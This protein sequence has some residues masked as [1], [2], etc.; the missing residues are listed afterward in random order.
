[1]TRAA[2]LLLIA[3]ARASFTRVKF[4]VITTAGA[5][6][7]VVR[8]HETWA[9]RGAQH[10]LELVAAEYFDDSRFFRYVEGFVVQFGLAG[11]PALTS[12]W[13]DAIKDDPV[14]TSNR[15]GTLAFATAGRDTRTT[16]L[17]VNLA[18][19]A[20]LDAQGF[21]PFG[22]LEA[23]GLAVARAVYDCGDD[24]EQHLIEL[25]G[26]TY[27]DSR[28]PQ[29]SRVVRARVVS[30]LSGVYADPNHPGC[31]RT[32][33]QRSES[34]A[35]VSGEDAAGAGSGAC[36]EGGARV[37]WGPLPAVLGEDAATGR[38]SLAVDFSSKGGPANLTGVWD[39]A[40]QHIVWAD[41]NVWTLIGPA[42]DDDGG[43]SPARSVLWGGGLPSAG[44]LISLT[45]VA[46]TIAFA[47][48][49]A[50]L[51]VTKCRASGK[52]AAALPQ[53][54]VEPLR[55][56][57]DAL[58]DDDLSDVAPYRDDS[59]VRATLPDGR[60]IELERVHAVQAH[61]EMPTRKKEAQD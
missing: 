26:N 24:P 1:M 28:F 52:P 6:S 56:G 34:A 48:N 57:D 54:D 35:E 30:S 50:Y 2:L 36:G 3:V 22:V 17:F 55:S 10:F 4:D 11:S 23:G 9:P 8:V 47:C 16:Q 39:N 19:N 18:D 60:V 32:V 61:L 46:C 25:R 37:A 43:A 38:P 7:F 12:Q 15:A 29:L 33:V 5:D 31:P 59:K 51:L 53:E 42:P 44:S 21:A 41:G 27:L 45:L 14:A 20:N 13:R 58:D 49:S 40:T